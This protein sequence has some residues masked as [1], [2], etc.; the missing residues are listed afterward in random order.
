VASATYTVQ[1]KPAAERDLKKIKDRT[2]LRRVVGAIDGLATNPRPPKVKALQ[3]DSSI[4]RIRV[5]DYR[6]LY[7]IEDAVLLVLVARIGHRREV[8]RGG[9]KTR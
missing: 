5:G 3:G 1:L 6:I 2:V 9:E 7:T 4:L 8:Y